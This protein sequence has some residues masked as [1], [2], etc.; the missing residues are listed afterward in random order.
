MAECLVFFNQVM[1][2]Y[3]VEFSYVDTSD[4]DALK[5]AMRRNTRIVWIETPTNPLMVLTDIREVSG[6][7]TP[8]ALKWWWTILFCHLTSSGRSNLARTW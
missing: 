7:L 4:L 5:K 6:L 2:N 1:A 8:A 3:G